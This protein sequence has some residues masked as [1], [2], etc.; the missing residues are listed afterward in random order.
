MSNDKTPN[1]P[2]LTDSDVYDYIHRKIDSHR[3]TAFEV[4]MEG[5]ETETLTAEQKRVLE[6]M[7]PFIERSFD[8][9]PT[10]VMIKSYDLLCVRK[11]GNSV[12]IVAVLSDGDVIFSFLDNCE[13]EKNNLF[14]KGE[15]LYSETISDP[16]HF[17]KHVEFLFNLLNI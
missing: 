4:Y 12:V 9:I 5:V 3:K 6:I 8:R 10:V 13:S 17:I 1:Y 11:K 2:N 16:A 15:C 14:L 7:T